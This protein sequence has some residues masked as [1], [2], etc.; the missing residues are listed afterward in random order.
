MNSRQGHQPATGG[1]LRAALHSYI[2]VARRPNVRPYFKM[3][4]TGPAARAAGGG[5]PWNVPDLCH[6]YNWPTGLAGGGVIAIVELGGGWVQSDMDQFFHGIN[7]PVP[8]ITDVSVDGTQNTPDPGPNSA[9]GEVALDIEV[10]AAAYYVA[11]GKPA[12]IRMYWAQDIASAVRA[13]N[14]RWLRRMLDFLGCGRSQLGSASRPGYGTSG[15]GRH[16]SGHGRVRCIR[17]Q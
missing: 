1:G 15:D 5:G 11:T 10:A 8:N 7:Q 2:H 13:A 3:G 12:T 14:G 6:A 9:D 16:R 17:R 4:P